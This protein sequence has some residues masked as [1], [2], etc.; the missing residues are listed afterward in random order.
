METDPIQRRKQIR[1]ARNQVLA[2]LALF[3]LIVFAIFGW[4]YWRVALAKEQNRFRSTNGVFTASVLRCPRAPWEI[5]SDPRWIV[6]YTDSRTGQQHDSH[7]KEPR[8]PIDAEVVSAMSQAITPK[9]AGAFIEVP[10]Q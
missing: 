8:S 4:P 1:R 2:Y 9:G 5:F 7:M 10:F 6:R 3:A